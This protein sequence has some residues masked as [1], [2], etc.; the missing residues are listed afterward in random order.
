MGVTVVV[1]ELALHPVPLSAPQEDMR[2]AA[3]RRP[4]A[5]PSASWFRP[6][7]H[8]RFNKAVQK[9][10]FAPAH[11]MQPRRCE[12][13]I[14]VSRFIPPVCRISDLLSRGSAC[15]VPRGRLLARTPRLLG[16]PMIGQLLNRRNLAA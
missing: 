2:G 11:G 8:L 14:A 4:V 15:T 6:V 13:G 12:S 9:A 16:I 10:P 1:R 3:V 5:T 7:G